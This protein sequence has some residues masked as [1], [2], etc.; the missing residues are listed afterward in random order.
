MIHSV[1]GGGVVG[2]DVGEINNVPRQ[3][4]AEAAPQ[5]KMIEGRMEKE[6]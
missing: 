1:E 3:V 5:D 2:V 6:S 4:C